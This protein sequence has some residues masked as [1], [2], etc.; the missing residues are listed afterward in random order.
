MRTRVSAYFAL[1]GLFLLLTAGYYAFVE[2]ER[3]GRERLAFRD[4]ESIRC[5][6]YSQPMPFARHCSYTVVC[7]AGSRLADANAERLKSLNR[8][9]ENDVVHLVIST[10]KVTDDSLGLL[11]SLK[12]VDVLDV[13]DSKISEAGK[14]VL[15]QELSGV[16]VVK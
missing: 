8:L 11:I 15:E 4:L 2:S 3:S 16:E 10:S 7:S 12:T 13:R 1:L 5:E 14:H 9:S 6:I